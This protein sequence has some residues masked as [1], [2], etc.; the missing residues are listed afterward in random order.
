MIV[1]ALV[2]GWSALALPARAETGARVTADEPQYL[3]TAISL[4]EDQSLDIR[5]ELRQRR[6]L[7][8]HEAQL[9]QQTR[10][11]D[12][13]RRVSPHDPL[14]PVILAV[15]VGLGGWA[16]GKLAMAM[17][18][19]ALA[20]A[21]LWVA[22]RRFNVPVNLGV[23]VVTGF[24]LVP[25][26]SVYGT[27]IYPELP[28]A[29][30]VTALIG[31]LTG[32]RRPA[33]I[34]AAAVVLALLPWLSIKYAPVVLGA[35]LWMAAVLVRERKVRLVVATSGVLS[36]SAVAFVVVHRAV[37]GGWTAYAA[38]DQFVNGELTVAGES[39][40]LAERSVRLL[41]LLTDRQFGLA[42]WAPAFLLAIAALAAL[43][44]RRPPGWSLL[45]IVLGAGWLNATFVALTMHG[46]WW[47]GR[48]VVVVVPV[49]VLAV[50]WFLGNARPARV[51]RAG[52]VAA[53]AAAVF[54][55]LWLLIEVLSGQ[56]QL[57][58]DFFETAAPI[59]RAWSSALPD[60]QRWEASDRALQLAWFALLA[61]LAALGWRSVP[62][63][64][65]PTTAPP[66]TKEKSQ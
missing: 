2:T 55:W 6:W 35:S 15:P 40:Q 33:A 52:F 50:A 10:P 38:G 32:R 25:P 59:Y 43:L 49:L 13:G 42:A 23:L 14:L 63:R 51:W 65:S 47:P 61:V 26:L 57:I 11:L 34:V 53:T 19:G 27:Q 17:L 44:R 29:L 31:L 45:A 24:A 39:P 21:L 41:G 37:Y 22:V 28:A 58:I 1:A 54:T 16:G 60:G 8:F 62:A 46:W 20:A 56:R 30:A 18:A 3:L 7:E 4:F 48:Q 12:N 66:I 64:R 9:P 5:D 36:L